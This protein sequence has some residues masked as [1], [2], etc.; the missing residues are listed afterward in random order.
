MVIAI[1]SEGCANDV[2]HQQR[3]YRRE[4][5]RILK[6]D[7]RFSLYFNI[8][9]VSDTATIGKYVYTIIV[10]W[11]QNSSNRSFDHIPHIP[12]IDNNIFF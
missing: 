5:S 11:P 3:A 4:K 8:L 2:E 1:L 9:K 7:K 10:T 6:K 12:D